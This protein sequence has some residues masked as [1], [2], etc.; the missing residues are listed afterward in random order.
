MMVCGSTFDRA[1]GEDR[2]M[3]AVPRDLQERLRQH[4]QEHVLAW[5]P[6]L[7][8]AERQELL[9]QLQALDLP[10]LRRLY[11]QRDRTW[12]LPPLD[13]IAPVPVARLDPADR[14]TRA[15]GEQALR[16]GE[17]AALVVAGGQGTR[18]GFDHPKGM[19]PTGP[20]SDKCLF[21]IH[22]EKV[23]ALAR[24]HGRPIP[25]LV[26]TSPATHAETEAFLRD[27]TYFGL[28]AEYVWL[29]CQG[30]MPALDLEGGR[31]LMEAPS[32]LFLSPNGHGGVLPALRDSGCL[33]RLRQ[34]GI[35]HLFYFQVDNPLVRVAD[36]LFL[37]HHIARRSEAS[38]KVVPKLTPTDKLGNLV[39][40]DGR[41]T[42]IEYS[43]LPEELARATD[44]HGS[45]RFS[46]GSPAIHIFDVD[47]L[48][49]LTE[50]EVGI[51]FHVARKKVSHIDE[52]GNPV[53]PA[54]ENAVKF[55]MFIFDVLPL[56]ERWAVVETSRTEEF[57]PLKNAAGP[58]S[59]ETVRRAL[60][61]L[62]GQWLER[63]GVYV[64][65]RPGGDVAVPLEISPLYA[66]DP[67]DLA[68]KADRRL[69]IDG[70]TY[71]E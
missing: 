61:N 4:G 56:A 51:P 45:L 5:W 38:S 10:R 29:F 30:T 66:L 46:A 63:A 65:R 11:E 37:G 20:V 40:I 35:R 39:L 70:P 26:M 31:L 2:A 21:Q 60:C 69:R 43:D 50:G 3:V 6:R 62:A 33:D 36:P 25:L 19:F 15:A 28:P 17:V 7:N 54:R 58:D 57:E 67:E 48:A 9:G 68:S 64:P 47:F 18:L 16:N 1:H 22:A 14:Q 44:E 13:K 71:L 27:Q 41:C 52:H 8:D 12:S 49:R 59:P 24:R 55:E 23:L 53:E 32:R 34:R 42:I